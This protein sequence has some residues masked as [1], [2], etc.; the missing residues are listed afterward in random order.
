[1]YQLFQMNPPRYDNCL[2]PTEVHQIYNVNNDSWQYCP[3][4]D[5][6]EFG[7][8]NKIRYNPKNC[9]NFYE[10]RFNEKG[11]LWGECIIWT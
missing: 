5:I 10:Y 9:P 7:S 11:E 4:I 2:Y 6:L 1:M 8:L 3:E